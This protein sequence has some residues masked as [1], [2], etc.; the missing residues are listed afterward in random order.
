MIVFKMVALGVSKYLIMENWLRLVKAFDR[1]A[2]C[3]IA[4]V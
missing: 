1:D 4:N 3:D 2:H